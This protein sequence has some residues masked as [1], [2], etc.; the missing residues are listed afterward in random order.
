MSKLKTPK[1]L[2][3]LY[4][5]KNQCGNNNWDLDCW[6]N[7]RI[8]QGL[9]IKEDIS[10]FHPENLI[11]RYYISVC[12][13]DSIEF[14]GQVWLWLFQTVNNPPETYL[15]C[16][17]ETELD[18]SRVHHCISLFSFIVSKYYTLFIVLKRKY[19]KSL[20]Y[21]TFQNEKNNKSVLSCSLDW[22]KL[23]SKVEYSD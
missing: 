2:L 13:L 19:W 4:C 18:L 5:H 15:L 6:L 3:C 21:Y 1:N 23:L 8:I 20:F 12:P 22:Q 16:V 9:F 10:Y 14:R 7:Q 17:L 11:G